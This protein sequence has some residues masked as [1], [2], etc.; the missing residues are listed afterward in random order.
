MASF[1]RLF[2]IMDALLGPEGCPW[3]RE[4]T[5]E[6]LRSTVLEET[7]E[8]IEAIDLGD[9][10]HM[11]EELGDLA[12]NVVF[13][14]RLGEKQGLFTTEQM[15][16]GICEKLIRR[17]PHVFADGDAIEDSEAVLEQWEKI[18]AEEKEKRESALDGLP[19]QLPALL[20]AH[21]VLK[22]SLIHI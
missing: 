4:Q 7:C 19:P 10:Y 16:E 6:S 3:D 5:V 21:K 12:F 20:R 15:L 9:P 8:L 13:F 2:E 11:A 22:L 18:K 14:C 1:D 17:H